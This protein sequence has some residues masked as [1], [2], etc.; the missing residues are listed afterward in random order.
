MFIFLGFILKH[1]HIKL[2]F[3]K[4]LK[5]ILFFISKFTWKFFLYHLKLLRTNAFFVWKK[6]FIKGYRKKIRKFKNWKVIKKSNL[7][8]DVVIKYNKKFKIKCFKRKYLKTSQK[9]CCR[10]ISP[11]LKK[12]K[13]EESKGKRKLHIYIFTLHLINLWWI[14]SIFRRWTNNF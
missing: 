4:I 9:R 5:K 10:N 1:K 6:T 14:V 2:Y 11:I 3:S 7:F 13:E 12:L 8:S